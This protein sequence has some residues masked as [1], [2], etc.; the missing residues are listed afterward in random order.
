MADATHRRSDRL[1]DGREDRPDD[2]LDVLARRAAA[3]DR[4]ALDALLTAVRPQV[5]ARC[6][7]V[8]PYGADAE[9]ACQEVLIAVVRGIGT[10]RGESRFTTWLYPIVSRTAFAVYRRMRER[11]AEPAAEDLHPVDPRRVSVLAGARVDLVEAMERL[12]ATA[13]H[14]AEAVVLRDLMG[15][16]YEEI[17]ARVDVPLGTVKS[18]VSLGRAALRQLLPGHSTAGV[19]G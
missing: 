12:R 8:L 16:T 13:P 15:M 2:R 6:A 3:G 7:R 17:A 4:D 14:Q 1:A 10:F 11:A 9:D 19:Q 5:L 18:R